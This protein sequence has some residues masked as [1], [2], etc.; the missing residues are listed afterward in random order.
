LEVVLK[1]GQLPRTQGLMKFSLEVVLKTGQLP[2]GQ[3][4]Q[5]GQFTVDGV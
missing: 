4:G 5:L 1:M 3:L 2:L